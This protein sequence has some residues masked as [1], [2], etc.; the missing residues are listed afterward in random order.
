MSL[1]KSIHKYRPFKLGYLSKE[2]ENRQA[3]L[4]FVVV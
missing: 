1:Q 2:I 4:R 3:E